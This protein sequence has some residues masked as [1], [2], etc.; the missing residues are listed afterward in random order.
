MFRTLS[1]TYAVS[2]LGRSGEERGGEEVRIIFFF[3]IFFFFE[4]FYSEEESIITVEVFYLST[5]QSGVLI[6]RRKLQTIC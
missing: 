4:F 1:V 2:T 3:Y 6:S 5:A